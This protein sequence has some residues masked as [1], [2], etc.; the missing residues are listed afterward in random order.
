M[1]LFEKIYICV[2]IFF[3]GNNYGKCKINSNRALVASIGTGV[4]AVYAV[5]LSKDAVR[6]IYNADKELR[7]GTGENF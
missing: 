3:N 6:A 5:V 7:K 1:I 4:A 2:K